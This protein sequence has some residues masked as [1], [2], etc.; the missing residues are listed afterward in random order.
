MTKHSVPAFRLSLIAAA[1][2]IVS[3]PALSATFEG[4]IKVN[5]STEQ[6]SPPSDSV[7]GY[8]SNSSYY[9]YV[10]SG[11]SRVSAVST[12]YNNRQ[13]VETILTFKQTVTNPYATAQN[14]TFDFHIPRSRTAISLGSLYNTPNLLS[15]S[16]AA[17][18]L[19]EIT[20]GGNSAWSV[21]YGVTGSGT[22]A[23]GGSIAING[24]VRSASASGFSITGLEGDG[25]QVRTGN[26]YTYNPDT[27][28]Y[29]IEERT[30]L[31][32]GAY[33]TSDNYYG[34]LALGTIGGNQSLELT[35]TLKAMTHFEGTYIVSSYS[36]CYGG[37]GGACATAGGYD[38]FGIEFEPAPDGLGIAL[39][40]TSAV[41]EPGSYA[42]MLGGLAVLSWAARRQRR[43]QHLHGS[44]KQ[45]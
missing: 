42:L 22:V 21:S 17:S 15:F 35:Y 8:G 6:S 37:Y 24:P 19:G 44:N 28:E 20:W 25:V 7:W 31:A 14:V 36:E 9:G 33:V 45:G 32:G 23:E 26:A 43:R 27:Y 3:L 30:G 4:E 16:A 5:G 41:P 34:S 39:S 1:A 29:D 2:W 11:S 12:D 13:W 38:P 40:F 18:M 10:W